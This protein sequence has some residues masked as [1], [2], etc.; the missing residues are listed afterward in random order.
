MKVK[1]AIRKRAYK[2]RK[3]QEVGIIIPDLSDLWELLQ[4]H[5]NCDAEWEINEKG[6]V[7][8]KLWNFRGEKK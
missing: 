6:E 4:R 2:E 7:A 3:N 8:M 1:V 5:D